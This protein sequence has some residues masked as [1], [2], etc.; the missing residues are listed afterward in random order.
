MF[1]GSTFSLASAASKSPSVSPNLSVRGSD[2]VG[3]RSRGGGNGVTGTSPP[4]RVGFPYYE[5][6]LVSAE[7]QGRKSCEGK[8]KRFRRSLGVR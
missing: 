3:D 1:T 6:V 8:R 7:R 5:E 4:I 2:V